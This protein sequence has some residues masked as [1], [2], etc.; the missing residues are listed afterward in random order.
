[1]EAV[2]HSRS[3]AILSAI[4][5]LRTRRPD[6]ARKTRARLGVGSRLSCKFPPRE[7]RVKTRATPVSTRRR[8]LA[9]F[10]LAARTVI[11][12]RPTSRTQP[13]AIHLKGARVPSPPY[14][15]ALPHLT[16]IL[17]FFN[18]G[19][20]GDRAQLDMLTGADSSRFNDATGTPRRSRGMSRSSPQ[21]SS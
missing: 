10:Y 18:T 20:A 7:G 21:L 14:P 9:R 17:V 11:S 16:E 12:G 15:L 4:P 13:R 19:L 1:M 2:R 5:A 6:V 3:I 8:S